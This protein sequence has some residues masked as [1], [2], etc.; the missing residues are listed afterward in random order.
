VPT[1]S[2]II[3]AYN[4][5]AYLKEALLSVLRQKGD[6]EIEVIVV[7]DG[8]IDGTAAVASAFPSVEYL[9]QEHSGAAQARNIGMQKARGEFVG[10]LDADDLF[11]ENKIALQMETLHNNPGVD[12]VFGHVS[13][14][15][16]DTSASASSRKPVRDE[17]AY[18]PGTMLMRHSLIEKIGL[19]NTSLPV[20]EFID[21]YSRA[22]AA[23][24]KDLMRTEVVLRRRLHSNNLGIRE[25]SASQSYAKVIGAHLKRMRQAGQLQ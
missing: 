24:L 20:G 8:S 6:H 5:E 9:C 14:F 16:D 23:G 22:R 2:I 19:F 3:P 25:S 7:D 18:L 10:F 17:A 4:A 12:A 13:E 1:V 21:W 11:V 15:I